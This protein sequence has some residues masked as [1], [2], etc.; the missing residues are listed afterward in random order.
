V[1]NDSELVYK[2]FDILVSE[3]MT[4]LP[5][6]PR[7]EGIQN[8]VRDDRYK[9]DEPHQ[10]YEV[11][12]GPPARLCEKTPGKLN[13]EKKTDQAEYKK[14]H[15]SQ[16]VQQDQDHED[17]KYPDAK[18]KHQTLVFCQVPIISNE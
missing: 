15:V 14:V 2:A 1:L 18:C 8:D 5:E 17:E 6:T 12:P 13:D 10:Y 16:V 4:Y 7:L 11:S 9:D 3:L